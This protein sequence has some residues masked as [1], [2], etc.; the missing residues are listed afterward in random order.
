V[1]ETENAPG[2][3]GKGLQNTRRLWAILACRENRVR[4]REQLQREYG[5][6]AVLLS[7][8]IPG[9]EKNA[10]PYEKAHLAGEQEF[11][12]RSEAAGLRVERKEI[13]RAACGRE[14]L[15]LIGLGTA[16]LSEVK[17]DSET[18]ALRLKRLC[19]QIEKQHPLGRIFDFDVYRSGG[20]AVGRAEL[21]LSQRRC[22]LCDEPARV[23]ARLGRHTA[24]DLQSYLFS[25]INRYFS[26]NRSSADAG[27][28]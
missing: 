11:L 3:E 19:I 7:M 10:P 15:F 24:E 18:I 1:C 20:S 22:F 8:N 23:C 9:A 28:S 21:Q 17:N 27:T 13:R 16:A 4:L 5:L 14:A 26:Q 6:P 12:Y 2:P 25:L